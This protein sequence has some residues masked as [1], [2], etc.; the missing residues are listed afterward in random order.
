M[1]NCFEGASSKPAKKKAGGSKVQ[2]P[3]PP[4]DDPPVPESPELTL[5]YWNIRGLAA[6]IR[7]LCSYTN[8][9]FEDIQFN[10]RKRSNGSWEASD[11]LKKTKPGLLEKNPFSNL[12]YLINHTSGEY[13]TTSNAILMY[14][15]RLTGLNGSSWEEETANEQILFVLH[16]LRIALTNLVYGEK[17]ATK[18]EEAYHKSLHNFFANELP[19]RYTQLEE[20]LKLHGNSFLAG[21]QPCTCDF[22]AWELLD[23]H[24]AMA[25][26]YQKASPL[27]QYPLLG[28][29]YLRFRELTELGMYFD[30]ADA[31]LPHNNKMAYF[32]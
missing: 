16:D 4:P 20:W 26:E 18:D 30:S 19:A 21:Q 32:K 12:P 13:I 23:Q 15:G 14:L 27:A 6:P 25:A 7:M 22:P 24:E 5:G 3:L 11:W 1:G 2:A 17:E 31:K 28:E 29:Y 9:D 10:L 8:L